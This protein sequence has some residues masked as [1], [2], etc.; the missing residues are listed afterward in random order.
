MSTTCKAIDDIIREVQEKCNIQIILNDHTARMMTKSLKNKGMVGD[1]R[2]ELVTSSM[3]TNVK[4][5]TCQSMAHSSK[6]PKPNSACPPHNVLTGVSAIKVITMDMRKS[7]LG[8]DL[9]ILNFT[10]QTHKT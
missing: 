10:I 5:N 2:F 4:M 6:W 7:R 1:T 3:S 9:P 8:I